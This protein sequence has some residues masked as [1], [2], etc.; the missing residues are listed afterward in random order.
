M[1]KKPM[2]TTA[3]LICLAAFGVTASHARSHSSMRLTR[4]VNI[5][6]LEKNKCFV[7]VCNDAGTVCV[8]AQVTCPAI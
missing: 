3:F 7:T 8:T 5:T 6:Q 2:L 4:V 1:S